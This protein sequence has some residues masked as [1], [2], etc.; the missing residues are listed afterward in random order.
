MD[1]IEQKSNTVTTKDFST[2]GNAVRKVEPS[3][4]QTARRSR[5]FRPRTPVQMARNAGLRARARA[6][7]KANASAS[8]TSVK[9][10]LSGPIFWLMI[11][12]A[13]IKD[14]S[15]IILTISFLLSILIIPLGIVVSFTLMLYYFF[16]GVKP[17]MGK[18][19]TVV[20]TAIIEFLPFVSLLPTTTLSLLIIRYLTN[21]EAKK[22]ADKHMGFRARFA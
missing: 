10:K 9:K 21:K 14:V 18:A 19:A 3:P 17:T 11:F 12:F 16:N 20:I 4:R 6:R 2:A 1:G 8:K 13:L 22:K 5:G 7:A 15:D